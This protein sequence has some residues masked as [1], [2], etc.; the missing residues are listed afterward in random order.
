LAAFHCTK[1]SFITLIDKIAT[2]EKRFLALPGSFPVGVC[3]EGV[4]ERFAHRQ[5]VAEWSGESHLADLSDVH[6]AGWK[7]QLVLMRKTPRDQTG[8]KSRAGLKSD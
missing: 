2:L 8:G 3:P 5:G 6:R 4:K 1:G 7:Q